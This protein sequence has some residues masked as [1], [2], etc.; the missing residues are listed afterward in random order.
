MEVEES[1]QKARRSKRA[2][3]LHNYALANAVGFEIAGDQDAQRELDEAPGPRAVDRVAWKYE[4]HAVV[5]VRSSPPSDDNPGGTHDPFWIAR[6]QR[7]M[8]VG[9]KVKHK[10]PVIS[11]MYAPS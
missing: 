1:Q 9:A 10:M 5:I 2:R 3:A 6:L 4:R 11:A 8:R 7:G